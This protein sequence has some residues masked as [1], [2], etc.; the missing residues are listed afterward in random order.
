MLVE[1]YGLD[2]VRYYLLRAIPFGS[3]GVFTP[4]EFCFSGELR[5]SE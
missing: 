4:E 2:A 1:R 5:F 3:D